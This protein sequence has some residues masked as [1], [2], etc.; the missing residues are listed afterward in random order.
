MRALLLLPLACGALA[1]TACKKEP[2]GPKTAEQ[3]KEEMADLASSAKPTPGKYRTTMKIVDVQIPGMDEAT[4][5]K[6]QGMFGGSGNASEHCLTPEMANKGF[7]EFGKHAAQG[8]CTYEKF[9]AGD[10]KLEAVMTC[11]TG[12]GAKTR[13]ELNG[14][15]T[16]TSSNMKMKT[17]SEAPGMPG[18]KMHLEAEVTSERIGDC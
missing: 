6:M 7:E 18:G 11:Q 17:D 9:S 15:F 12:Q 4:A 10:G 14:T 16:S 5:K 8:N 2:E 13:S 3:V 1:L